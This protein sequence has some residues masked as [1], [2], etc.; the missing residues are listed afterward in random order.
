M[1]DAQREQTHEI[2]ARQSRIGIIGDHATVHGGIHF[3]TPSPSPTEFI[4]REEEL[5][6]LS[7]SI[8][9]EDIAERLPERVLQE[10]ADFK[11]CDNASTR[12]E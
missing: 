12:V 6:C 8:E 4:G 5:T 10:N 2:D 11:Y 7:R 9:Q 3:H 1:N